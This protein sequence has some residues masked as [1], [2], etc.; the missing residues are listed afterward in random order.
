MK[1]LIDSKFKPYISRI[2][3]SQKPEL[4]MKPTKKTLR[5]NI[6]R[7]TIA[8]IKT[9]KNLKDKKTQ[10]GIIQKK[11]KIYDFNLAFLSII[12][13]FCAIMDNEYYIKKT[14]SFMEKKYGFKDEDL[15]FSNKN[16]LNK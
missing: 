1:N 16:D 6:S 5:M 4:K 8:Q 2:S 9:L 12:S 13:I 7:N 3:F 14:F 10:I 15:L 11:M